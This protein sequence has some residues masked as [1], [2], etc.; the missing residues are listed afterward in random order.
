MQPNQTIELNIID[1]GMEGE[2]IGKYQDY[3]FFVPYALPGEIVKAKI[4]HLKKG[5]NVGYATLKEIVEPSQYRVKPPCNRFTRC[6]GCTL[7]HLD[8]P[9]QLEYKKK[10]VQTI[11]RKNAG[12]LGEI[13]DVVPSNSFAYRNKAQLPFGMV[14]GK[15]AVGF[16][17]TGTHKVVSSKK[18]FLHGDWL[19][20]LIKITLDFANEEGLSVYDEESKKGLLRHLVAR[21]LGNKMVVTLVIN[22]TTVKNI[23][24]YADRLEETFGGVALYLNPNTRDTN[25]IMGNTLIPILPTRQMVEVMGVSIA[26]NPFSFFQVNDEIREKLYNYVIDKVAPNE[27]TVV[28]DAYAGVG[29]LGAIMA[30][31]GATI[32]NIEIVKEATLDANELYEANGILDRVTNICGDASI[33]L[34]N[35]VKESK[36]GIS[37][38][39]S[40][41]F[42]KLIKSGR[43]VKII[44]DP[45]R[46]GISKEVADTL[47]ELSRVLDFELFYISC[48]PATLSRDIANLSEFTPREITPFDMFPNTAHVETVVCLSKK[49]GKTYQ[50]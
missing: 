27:N 40:E 45:P 23:D 4:T 49:N 2:G 32:F 48:N 13:N 8:Y 7:M 31:R 26:V 50:H 16:Y 6:G 12:Y 20:K 18:C 19:E 11:L 42:A 25:V 28:V 22:G 30:K 5:K 14:N 15:V 44:L 38:T 10:N 39:Q 33:E 34:K 43:K 24:K 1:I 46:K 29:L 9:K 41:K 36:N 17:G 47:N 21:Y 3:T 35:L 37:S